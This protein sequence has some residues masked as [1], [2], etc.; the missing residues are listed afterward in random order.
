MRGDRKPYCLRAGDHMARTYETLQS[1]KESGEQML[2]KRFKESY[3]L[4]QRFTIHGPRNK[5]RPVY[6]GVLGFHER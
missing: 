1:A 5:R 6:E 3:R 4:I 2:G